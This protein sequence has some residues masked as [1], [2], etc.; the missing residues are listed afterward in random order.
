MH[1]AI[2]AD[3]RRAPA[4]FADPVV[5]RFGQL[6]AIGTQHVII[7]LVGVDKEGAFERVPDL[8][9]QLNAL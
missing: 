3:P 1:P 4:S 7:G 5:D 6:H 8:V 2:L 9:A